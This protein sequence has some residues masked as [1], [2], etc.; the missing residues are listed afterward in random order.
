[1]GLNAASDWI[2][3]REWRAADRWR[4]P[5][6]T[7]MRDEEEKCLES[8]QKKTLD[9]D[10]DLNATGEIVD[11]PHPRHPNSAKSAKKPH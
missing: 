8:E 7:A 11:G 5:V 6:A 9:S 10:T 4:P 1:M 2:A 3:Y